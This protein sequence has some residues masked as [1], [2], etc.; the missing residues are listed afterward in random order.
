MALSRLVRKGIIVRVASGVYMKGDEYDSMPE[1]IQVAQIKAK[2][3]GKTL[4]LDEDAILK[5]TTVPSVTAGITDT[6][7]FRVDGYSSSFQYGKTKVILQSAN[8][9]KKSKKRKL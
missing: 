4:S 7:V 1:L 6:I 9:K 5:G 3:F 2:A 8:C